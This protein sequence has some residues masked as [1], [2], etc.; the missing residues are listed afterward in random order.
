MATTK[1]AANTKA[2][3][4]KTAA[5]AE[6]KEQAAVATENATPPSVQ[7][8]GATPPASDQDQGATPPAS[9]QDQGGE[10][11]AEPP[12]PPAKNEPVKALSVT[13]RV[14][15]FRRAG[16]AWSGVATIVTLTELSD[17]Q[18]AMLK[19]EPMLTVIEVEQGIE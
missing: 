19:S 12:A 9:D 17:E 1:K 4:S 5:P 10:P 11:P 15:G 3:A 6:N 7:D 16:R 13:S 14:E 18:V 8:Q 2:N